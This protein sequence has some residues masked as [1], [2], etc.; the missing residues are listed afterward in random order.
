MSKL[1]FKY[2]I[3]SRGTEG[4]DNTW[5]IEDMETGEV[6]L[7]DHI[8]LKT[9]VTTLE[10]QIEGKGFGMITHGEIEYRKYPD[11]DKQ[12]IVIVPES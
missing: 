12:F 7:I 9:P 11:S 3:K 4:N 10:K 2:N 1:L 6:V 5:S 8:E